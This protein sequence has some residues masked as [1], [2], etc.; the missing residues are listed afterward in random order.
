[1]FGRLR[2]R[3][4]REGYGGLFALGFCRVRTQHGARLRQTDGN[5]SESDSI[6]GLTEAGI[7]K[8]WFARFDG[9]Q[10]GVGC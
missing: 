7:Y 8:F 4:L 10:R 3:G 6:L 2:G 9:M 5:G 1:M